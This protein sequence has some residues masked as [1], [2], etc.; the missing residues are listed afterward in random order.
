MNQSAF[1]DMTLSAGARRSLRE[2]SAA[3]VKAMNARRGRGSRW[4][5]L[6]GFTDALQLVLY[7]SEEN[8]EHLGFEVYS[9]ESDAWTVRRAAG[10]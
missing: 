10:R 9:A 8:L 7:P 4:H 6:N 1:E 2:I 3:A 5:Y